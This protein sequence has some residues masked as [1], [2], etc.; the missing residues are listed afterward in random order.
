MYVCIILYVYTYTTCVYVYRQIELEKNKKSA[1]RRTRLNFCGYPRANYTDWYTTV[2]KECDRMRIARF[3]VNRG[4]NVLCR[5]VSTGIYAD[6][7][8]TGYLRCG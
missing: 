7:E 1:Q 3:L 6:G 2:Y 4:K 8:G 5:F